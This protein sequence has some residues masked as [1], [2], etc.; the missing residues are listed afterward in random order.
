MIYSHVYDSNKRKQN[1][2]GGQVTVLWDSHSM[3]IFK[4]EKYFHLKNNNNK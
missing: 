2:G 4:N 1:E 3:P